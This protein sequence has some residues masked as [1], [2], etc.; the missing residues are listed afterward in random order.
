[1]PELL[2][3]P[4]PENA[5]NEFN[6]LSALLGRLGLLWADEATAELAMAP[7]ATFGLRT[8]GAVHLAAAVG[9]GTDRYL[10]NNRSELLKSITEIDVTDP[11]EL[12]EPA[13]F[14]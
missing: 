6:E 9:A 8:A 14:V 4:R 1:M 7:G 11:D 10:T 12:A 3:K 13:T 2:T 5:A